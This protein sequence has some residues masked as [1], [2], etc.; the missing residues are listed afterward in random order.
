MA[1][2]DR[3][4]ACRDCGTEFAFTAGEQEFYS[5]KGFEHE[6]SRCAVCRH[7]RKRDRPSGGERTMYDA[8]CS[9]CGVA[10]QVPFSPQPEK[11]VYCADCYR[12]VAG[13]RARI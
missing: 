4:L 11:P 8:V 9:Q 7:A 5:Q 2:Q 6:P 3:M 13:R 10:T 12:A 1:L